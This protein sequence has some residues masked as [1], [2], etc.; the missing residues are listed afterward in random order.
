[1][2]TTITLVHPNESV[3]ISGRLLVQKGNLFAD[4]LALGASPYTLQSPVSL[5]DFRTFV[6]PLEGDTVVIRNEDFRGLSQLC[7][8]FRFGDLVAQLARFGEAGNFNGEAV[9]LLEWRSEYS[10][11]RGRRSRWVTPFGV[12]SQA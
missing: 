10:N 4:N 12:I 2:T 8:E 7:E 5:D 6:S 1:M 11:T 9:H 3:R